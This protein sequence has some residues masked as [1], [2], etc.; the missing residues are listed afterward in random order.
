MDLRDKRV[1]VVYSN[2][3]AQREG[4][5]ESPV[6]RFY[7]NELSHE[8][9]PLKLFYYGPCYRYEEPQEGR[10]REFWQFGCEQIGAG[11]EDPRVRPAVEG[12]EVLA[13]HL[14]V[15]LRIITVRAFDLEVIYGSKLRKIT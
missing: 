5:M 13:H 12:K 6:L 11:I 1:V 14:R 2:M 3:H 9:K 15:V 8:P 10:Y 4:R 7:V